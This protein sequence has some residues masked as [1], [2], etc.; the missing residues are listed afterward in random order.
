LMTCFFFGGLAD[1]AA[2]AGVGATRG[3]DFGTQVFGVA[4]AGGA[5]VVMTAAAPGEE[6]S[7]RAPP[8][9]HGDG[10]RHVADSGGGRSVGRLGN[11]WMRW[12]ED[13]T[14]DRREVGEIHAV[15]PGW[16]RCQR[17]RG[18][19]DRRRHGSSG[20][21]GE[22]PEMSL[23]PTAGSDIGRAS[24]RLA[25]LEIPSSERGIYRRL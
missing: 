24:V 13:I 17:R 4:V 8:L 1:G 19:G 18:E 20:T 7:A 10:F 14:S 15:D 12:R 21:G 22:R 3:H 5:G 23:P 11:R 25:K 16:G 2:A 9:L 6:V